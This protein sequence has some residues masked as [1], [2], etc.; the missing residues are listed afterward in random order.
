MASKPKD[1]QV[2]KKNAFHSK[3]IGTKIAVQTKNERMTARSQNVA[4]EK[5]A[6]ESHLN[7]AKQ[8]SVTKQNE[9]N[10]SGINEQKDQMK[11]NPFMNEAKNLSVPKTNR[12]KVEIDRTHRMESTATMNQAKKLTTRSQIAAEYSGEQ[13]DRNKVNTVM[14]RNQ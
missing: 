14:T 7:P 6:S 12:L 13:I 11:L 1:I 8:L 5:N 10:A 3:I 9:M 4:D 2:G